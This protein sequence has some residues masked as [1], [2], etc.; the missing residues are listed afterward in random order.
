[1][2]QQPRCQHLDHAGLSSVLK[3]SAPLDRVI[4]HTANRSLEIPPPVSEFSCDP[5]S[6]R[7]SPISPTPRLHFP[8]RNIRN[9]FALHRTGRPPRPQPPNPIRL[10]HDP[11]KI[12][13]ACDGIAG[14]LLTNEPWAAWHPPQ[15]LDGCL[16]N[17][18]FLSVYCSTFYSLLF[19]D[20][21]RRDAHR[22]GGYVGLV[23][24]PDSRTHLA[25]AL[26]PALCQTAGGPAPLIQQIL[27]SCNHP[28]PKIS[29][30]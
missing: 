20:A 27:N 1:M 18:S 21:C 3:N 26:D 2:P 15:R 16:N 24:L 19:R 10:N 13:L 12:V 17:S 25:A 29:S 9:T 6:T 5:T 8:P 11:A 28:T 23:E 4:W 30:K 14:T 22:P 7:A